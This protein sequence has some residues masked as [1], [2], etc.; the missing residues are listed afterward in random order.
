MTPEELKAKKAE[1][2]KAWELRKTESD[3]SW[4]E[5]RKAKRREQYKL[6]PYRQKNAACLQRQKI[7]EGPEELREQGRVRNRQWNA[8]KR[9]QDPS[10]FH[11]RDLRHKYGMSFAEF[12]AMLAAQ[13]FQCAICADSIDEVTRHVDHD[14]ATGKVRA[15]LCR[16]CNIALGH[17]RDSVEIARKVASYLESHLTQVILKEVK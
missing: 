2:Y 17:L 14:H 4:Y 1:A 13:S 3:P 9:A 10:Y 6:F 8:A 12:Q 11:D 5:R 7:R 16:H 15:L